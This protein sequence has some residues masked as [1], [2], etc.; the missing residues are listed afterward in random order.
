[1]TGIFGQEDKPSELLHVYSGKA[2]QTGA[3]LLVLQEKCPVEQKS[4]LTGIFGQ[5][6]K[7]SELLQ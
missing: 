3:F 6:D 1:M 4:I 2:F 5:E 7:L